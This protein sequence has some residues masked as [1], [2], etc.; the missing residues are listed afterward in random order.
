MVQRILES[1]E[2]DEVNSYADTIESTS[3]ANIIKET[4]WFLVG[5]MDLPS[6]H[7]V[8]QLNASGDSTKPTLMTLPSSV[9]DID[10][11]K[12]QDLDEE[13]NTEFKEMMFMPLKDFLEMTLSL[14][15]SETEVSTMV[16]DVDGTNFT[17]KYYNDREP[18]Y[19]TTLDDTNIVFDAYDSVVDTTLQASKTLCYGKKAP[20]FTMSDTF[21]PKLD[22]DQFQLLLN[23]AKTQAFV[24][25]KQT[26]NEHSGYRA[27][28]SFIH[29]QKTKHNVPTGRQ[30]GY[31]TYGRK[32]H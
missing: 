7:N 4:Y 30:K 22:Q 19:Y 9:V 29:T 25:L 6:T 1:M 20:D 2:S 32:T 28:K 17:F 16:L 24:E 13:N 27:R 3:V 26:T 10:Y 31:R 5:R 8:F 14:D 21:T 12:Y 11:I 15:E 18:T 23:E